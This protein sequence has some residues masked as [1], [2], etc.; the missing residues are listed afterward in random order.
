MIQEI[1]EILFER[2]YVNG[3]PGAKQQKVQTDHTFLCPIVWVPF[4]ATTK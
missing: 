1:T 2:V 4:V 3:F